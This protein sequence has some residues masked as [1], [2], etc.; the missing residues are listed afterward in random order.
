LP[1]KVAIAAMAIGGGYWAAM[2]LTPAW[3]TGSTKPPPPSDAIAIA[4]PAAGGNEDQLILEVLETLERRPNIAAKV[5]QSVRLGDDRLTGE[6]KFWQ[7]GVGNQRRTRWE[8]TT[9]V[10]GERAFVTQVYD[11]DVV[12]TDRKLPAT[13]KVTRIDV[14]ALRRQLAVASGQLGHDPAKVR[15]DFHELMARGGISQLIAGLHHCFEFGPRRAFTRGQQTVFAVIGR[16]RPD[17]LSRIWPGL[18]ADSAENWP[19]QLPHHVVIYVDSSDRFPYLIEY[20]GGEQAALAASSEGY[21][22]AR[23]ALATYEFIEVQFAAAMPSDTFQ[24]TP[25]D[26]SWQDITARIVNELRPPA[27]PT[28]EAAVPRT[29][30]WRQ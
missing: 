21:A 9:L 10:A 6:G 29:G 12:W 11:G 27:A 18:S 2:T 19:A 4:P 25:P 26:N 23:D 8:I 22:P 16:W 14:S 28:A 20:R 3:T 5:L 13:R 15:D 17:E 24:F 30:S 1:L 7:Q